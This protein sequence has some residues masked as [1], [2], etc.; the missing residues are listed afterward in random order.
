ML[1]NAYL[2]AFLFICEYQYYNAP[3]CNA[4][5]SLI[6]AE[7]GGRLRMVGELMAIFPRHSGDLSSLNKFTQTAKVCGFTLG[8]SVVSRVLA[9]T[10]ILESTRTNSSLD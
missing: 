5:V 8:R 1:I 6:R 10:F 4:P 7:G 3:I 9:I 2:Y